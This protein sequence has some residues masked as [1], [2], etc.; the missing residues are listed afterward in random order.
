MFP[1]DKSTM[2]NIED[3]QCRKTGFKKVNKLMLTGSHTGYIF[4]KCPNKI[5]GQGMLPWLV[6]KGC[7]LGK[8]KKHNPTKEWQIYAFSANRF[9]FLYPSLSNFGV[10]NT[11]V[12]T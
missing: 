9:D 3:H 6:G 12:D 2:V 4:L 11:K 10:C 5:R 1:V 8:M 7:H